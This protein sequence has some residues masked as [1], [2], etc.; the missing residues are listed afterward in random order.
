MSRLSS[1]VFES[2]LEQI[3]EWLWMFP[4]KRGSQENVSWWLN[5]H[6]EPV[7]IDCPEINVEV[8]NDLKKLSKGLSPKILLTNRDSHGMVTQLNKELGWPVLIQEQEAY[9]LPAIKNLESFGDEFVTSSKLRV[10][11]T[12]GPTPGSCVV[13]A[14]DPWNVLF[15]GRL[16]SPVAKDQ[17]SSVRTRRTFHWTIQQKSLEKLS[18]LF[19]SKHRPLLASGEKSHLLG[20]QKLLPWDAW[21]KKITS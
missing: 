12:P 16:L 6:P 7:L 4:S 15:C 18:L 14:P 19:S 8:I 5:S 21:Q 2:S 10:F 1:L 17:I 3:T 11:W 9:L 20:D 13:Y